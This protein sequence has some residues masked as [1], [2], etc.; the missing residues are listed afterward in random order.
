MSK[1]DVEILVW[2]WKNYLPK[3]KLALIAG[4]SKAGKSTLTLEMA[5]VVSNGGTFPDGSKCDK[6]GNVL[7]WTGEDG[8]NDTV[9]PRLLA[10]GA[11]EDRVFFVE[12][13]R[14]I[15]TGKLLPFSPATDM[16]LLF[17]YVR[18]MKEAPA[19]LIIDPI[20]ATTKKDANQNNFVR[21]GLEPVTRFAEEFDCC[22]LGITH[23]KKDTQGQNILDRVISSIA[24]VAVARSILVAAKHKDSELR[25]FAQ[26]AGN[27]GVGDLGGFQYT[28]EATHLTP[29]SVPIFPDAN[30]RPILE[31]GTKEPVTISKI[32]WTGTHLKGTAEKLVRDYEQP[33]EQEKTSTKNI[34]LNAAITLIRDSM[35]L[36]ER[37]STDMDIITANIRPMSL[38][39][40]AK[41]ALCI[42]PGKTKTCPAKG[43]W[44]IVNELDDEFEDEL[45][46]S[47]AT[48]IN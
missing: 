42:Q 31:A 40:E 12:S 22:V 19:L 35:P 36:G 28:I 34:A 37:L 17:T 14:D 29:A 18:T 38:L 8:L 5:A 15:V 39:K 48:T 25:V 47:D 16:E 21:E 41:R 32:N 7:I 45:M 27:L 30:G 46:P 1:E 24:W 44:K 33:E 6:P 43:T 23:F 9:L 2:L 4:E 11:N 26:A 13:R 10:M 20:V 3:R